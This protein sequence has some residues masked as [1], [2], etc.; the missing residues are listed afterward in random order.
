MSKRFQ[1][2]GMSS[3]II[4]FVF[5]FCMVMWS[6]AGYCADTIKIK[7]SYQYPTDHYSA[8]M[9]EKYAKMLREASG[10]RLE[11]TTYGNAALYG[12]EKI[13]GGLGKG[14]V[15]MGS[16]NTSMLAS[17]SKDFMVEGPWLLHTP[18][19]I[20]TF[21]TN[22][23]VGRKT[24][25]A[26]EIKANIKRV[27]W[28]PI[29]PYVLASAKPVRTLE[30]LSSLSVRYPSLVEAPNYHALKMKNLSVT[31]GETYTALER[32]MINAVASLPSAMR[33]YGWWD[34]AKYWTKPYV[35]YQS[36]FVGLNMDVW[37]RLP[38]DLKEVFLK[39]GEQ[40]SKESIQGVV[41]YSDRLFDELVKKKGGQVIT[42]SAPELTRIR[43]QLEV[44]GAYAE[45]QK[46]ISP[47]VWDAYVKHCGYKAAK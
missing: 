4:T 29:G 23:E 37:K 24:W 19:Q 26:M 34:N 43:K 5:V 27:A 13:V 2:R 21:W 9:A 8:I 42:L 45:F 10:G 6:P 41:E 18:Q 30:D 22:T 17:I 3:I 32:G 12:P 16:V 11:I 15:E 36:A 7:F 20:M 35:G 14:V 39:V 28:I 44:G 25:A 33:G 1:T 47:A 46:N 31:T 40:I 38:N